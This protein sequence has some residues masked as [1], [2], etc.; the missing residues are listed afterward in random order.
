MANE[1]PIQV[2]IP[3]SEL[4]KAFEQLKEA[5]HPRVVYCNEIAKMQKEAN[6]IATECLSCVQGYLQKW[7]GHS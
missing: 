5:R 1:Q 3:L 4:E 2:H 6:E 7:I